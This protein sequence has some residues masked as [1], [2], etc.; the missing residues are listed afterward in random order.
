MKSAKQQL[1]Q[2]MKRKIVLEE[3]LKMGVHTTQDGKNVYDCDFD[4]LKYE[5]VLASFRQ[6]DRQKDESKWF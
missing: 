4:D 6:I 3:L 2:E 5:L 1:H